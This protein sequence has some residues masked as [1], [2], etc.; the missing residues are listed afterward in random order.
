RP[1]DSGV[2]AAENLAGIKVLVVDD[3]ADSLDVVRRI[4]TR[5]NA[6]VQ[7]AASVQQAL[8]ILAPFGPDVI[9]SDIGMPVHD[10]YELIRRVRES[11]SGRTIPA[12][13]LTALARS[14][15]RMHALQAGFQ[16]H[17]AKPVAPAELIAV[18]RSLAGLRSPPTAPRPA[19]RERELNNSDPA[20]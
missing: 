1:V 10:G 18:V 15:D 13:A 17:V 3:D 4:L 6:E 11:V 9:L 2:S 7:T 16:T 5:R 14:E 19:Q 12:A 20:N 8:E